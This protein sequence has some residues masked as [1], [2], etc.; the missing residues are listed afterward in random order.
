MNIKRR[1][2]GFTLV[3]LLTV[4]III[5]LLAA[6]LLPTVTSAIKTAMA[7][8]SRTRVNSLDKGCEL[9]KKEYQLY[10]GQRYMTHATWGLNGSGGNKTGSQVLAASMYLYNLTNPLPT[11][12]T[13]VPRGGFD[14]YKD[15]FLVKDGKQPGSPNDNYKFFL[16]DGF[17]RQQAYAILYY[18]S[19]PGS[20]NKS[21]PNTPTV[22]NYRYEHN[23]PHTDFLPVNAHG[24]A[25]NQR[26]EFFTRAITDTRFGTG[27]LSKP[28]R[29]NEFLL[30]APGPD[31]KYFTADDIRNF[32]G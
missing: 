27:N 19:V 2:A 31:R 7:A 12:N 8:N 32:G 1:N 24:T 18:P 28:Y 26:T 15:E 13:V 3:E 21:D 16:S 23:Q 20:E 22:N 11:D 14:T 10:P 5:G 25:T 9:Y 30:I 6:I 4:V 17:P 29:Y